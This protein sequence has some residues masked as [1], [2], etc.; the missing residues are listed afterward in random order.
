MESV[1]LTITLFLF[2]AS[3]SGTNLV[4]ANQLLGPAL[5]TP[6]YVQTIGHLF[7]NLLSEDA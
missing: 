3:I 2:K 4:D 1:Y 6:T 5:V 7:F